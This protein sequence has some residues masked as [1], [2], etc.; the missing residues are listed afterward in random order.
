MLGVIVQSLR[1]LSV[2]A[3]KARATNLDIYDTIYFMIEICTISCCTVPCL[4]SSQVCSF[5][6]EIAY[7]LSLQ[8]LFTIKSIQNMIFC[9]LRFLESNYVC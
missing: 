7:H 1:S 2:L 4:T 8:V 6:R 9:K 3:G 5:F